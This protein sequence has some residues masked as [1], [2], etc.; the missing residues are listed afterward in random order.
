[1]LCSFTLTAPPPP[2][3]HCLSK[4]KKHRQLL[5]L[6]LAYTSSRLCL[7]GNPLNHVSPSPF[8]LPALP[9]CYIMFPQLCSVC[10]YDSVILH[11]IYTLKINLSLLKK[12]WFS[13]MYVSVCTLSVCQNVSL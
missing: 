8:S 12:E 4:R 11:Y 7:S 13:N 9:S 10:S 5:P 6:I 1:M 2:P 3:P